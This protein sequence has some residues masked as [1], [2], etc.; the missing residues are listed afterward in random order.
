MSG[1][2]CNIKED[3]NSTELNQYSW[4]NHVNMLYIDQPVGTSFSYSTIQNGTLNVLTPDPP[5][6]TPL[7]NTTPQTNATLMA[8]ALDPRPLSTTQNT[9]Q[10]ASR[11][12]WQFAQ[13]W[14]QE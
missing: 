14:F 2:P 11:T 4:N 3:S 9:T 8:A 7:Q 6:F 5:L 10:Q 13:V 12:I 1:F